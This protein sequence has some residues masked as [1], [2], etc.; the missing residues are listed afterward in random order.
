VR[1]SR[2]TWRRGASP[3]LVASEFRVW[4]LGDCGLSEGRLRERTQ[5]YSKSSNDDA[6]PLHPSRDIVYDLSPL[7]IRRRRALHKWS[8]GGP[9]RREVGPDVHSATPCGG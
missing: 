3:A 6:A 7:L 9:P 1:T 4:A 2:L 5:E 8:E